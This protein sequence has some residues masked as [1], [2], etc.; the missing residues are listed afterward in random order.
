[1]TKSSEIISKSQLSHAL[2]SI[3]Q[4]RIATFHYCN[5]EKKEL[6]GFPV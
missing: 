5:R 4:D 3:H 6:L 2:S 1:M